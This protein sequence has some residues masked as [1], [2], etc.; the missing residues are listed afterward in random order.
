[1]SCKGIGGTSETEPWLVQQPLEESSHKTSEREQGYI[2][3]QITRKDQ[4]KL[5]TAIKERTVY[6]AKSKVPIRTIGHYPKAES[7]SSLRVKGLQLLT[8]VAGLP[9]GKNQRRRT[10]VR[11]WTLA[12]YGSMDGAPRSQAKR[13]ELPQE[14][15]CSQILERIPMGEAKLRLL[16]MKNPRSWL[17]P[18]NDM[19]KQDFLRKANALAL[20]PDHIKC[21]Q[22]IFYCGDDSGKIENRWYSK[23]CYC[24]ERIF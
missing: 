11:K 20:L 3:P 19:Q 9:Q 10:R 18:K 13:L 2:R 8:S 21:S 14:F 16:A 24:S 6:S 12:N 22:P 1:M 7:N 4:R 23:G 5:N 15:P 17:A